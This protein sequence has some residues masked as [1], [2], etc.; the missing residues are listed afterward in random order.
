[1]LKLID[2]LDAGHILYVDSYYSSLELAN[3]LTQAK[4]GFV[5]TVKKKFQSLS[6]E[7]RRKHKD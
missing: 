6:S 1:V 5:G 7:Q 2:G 3:I 4:I